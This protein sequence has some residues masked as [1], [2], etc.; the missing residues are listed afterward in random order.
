MIKSNCIIEV[1]PNHTDVV[2]EF[3]VTNTYD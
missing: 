3:I 2:V 1:H